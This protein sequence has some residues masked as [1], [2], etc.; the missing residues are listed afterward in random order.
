MDRRT[1]LAITLSI[2]I[3]YAWL[4]IR[5]PQ[6]RAEQEAREAEAAAAAEQVE[7]ADVV[8]PPV[9][10]AAPSEPLLEEIPER[11]A[12]FDMCGA[13]A[14]FSTSGGLSGLT[15]REHQGPY[16][17]QPL[18]SWLWGKITG[19]VE[20]GWHPWGPAE[21]GPAE[22]VGE[23]GRALVVGT[24]AGPQ[25]DAPAR[26][27]VVEESDDSWLLRGR[28]SHGLQVEQRWTRS[29]VN[30][31][32]TIDVDVTWSN[33][34]STPFSGGL[35][36]S[37]HDSAVSGGSGMTARYTSQRQPTAVVGDDL[38]YGGALGAGCVQAGTRLSDDPEE[39][40]F[41]LEGPVSWFGVS[42]RY[43]GFYLVP[44]EP[45]AVTG[46]L[47]RLGAGEQALDG[48]HVVV[49]GP[50]APGASVSQSFTAYV[51]PNDM[52]TLG[53][54]H[55]ELERVVDLGWFAFF[56][57]PLLWLLRLFYA[58]VGNWGV[59]IV[60]LT[61]VVKLLFF[62]MTQRSFRSM[63]KMQQIQPE[64]NRIRE[65]MADNP[66]EMNKKLFEV[67][68]EN[69]VNPAAGCL[70]MVVQMPVW[71][72]LYNVLLTSVDLYHTEFLYLRDLTEPDP[73]LV[74]PITIMVL[75]FVQQQ[76]STPTNMDPTQQQVMR[77]MP[78]FFGLLFFA[79]P[80]GL[81]VYVF[82]NMVLSNIQQWLIKRNL[83]TADTPEAAAA[84]SS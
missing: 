66:Q 6:L 2:A 1:L 16:A 38:Y 4:S 18:Y 56:G 70:P 39:Q 68:Q 22:V 10:P 53:A 8:V 69:N 32:C 20:G 23:Y 3:Y 35:W 29:S 76:F 60:M 83:D 61:L 25:V 40:S 59:A 65:E 13:E 48:T 84:A 34:S 24:G 15:L 64:L 30:D 57:Y 11:E 67:M 75:M 73:Y 79:F 41:A 49:E 44:D 52:A 12:P 36:L 62:P 27:A 55:E 19:S 28:S 17:V 50:L 58:G 82:V 9:A 31:V 43:F 80:S 26:L 21:P 5:G 51:G 63:Q 71:I 46:Y 42:D 74:L 54:V 77:L 78:L 37:M 7:P 72:A 47:S 81:A 45:E 33:T 14:T